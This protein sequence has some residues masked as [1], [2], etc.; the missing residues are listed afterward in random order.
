MSAISLVG[1]NKTNTDTAGQTRS[2]ADLETPGEPAGLLISD[3]IEKPLDFVSGGL[4]PESILHGAETDSTELVKAT[5]SIKGKLGGLIPKASSTLAPGPSGG[6]NAARSTLVGVPSK[7]SSFI[8]K[9][10]K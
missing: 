3:I 10:G 7:V 6:A 1:A 5:D 8:A 2:A 9:I 4:H